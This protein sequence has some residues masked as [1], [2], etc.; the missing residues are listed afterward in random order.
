MFIR[1]MTRHTELS[2]IYKACEKKLWT[3]L[4]FRREKNKNEL[5]KQ[6]E[7]GW[8][9]KSR[10]RIWRPAFDKQLLHCSWALLLENSIRVSLLTEQWHKW[11][12]SQLC[13]HTTAKHYTSL[14]IK[15]V[16]RRHLPSSSLTGDFWQ[17]SET[18]GGRTWVISIHYLPWAH[19]K[20][21]HHVIEA[22]WCESDNEEHINTRWMK[23]VI[24]Q[25]HFPLAVLLKLAIM[26]V[27]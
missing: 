18:D 8:E 25:F 21:T 1:H 17:V 23:L 5:R 13:T 10:G 3:V 20:N 26:G 24:L 7:E 9:I 6:A 12:Q 22:Y 16:S 11:K 14:Y 15:N 19:T 4:W 27:K 2:S